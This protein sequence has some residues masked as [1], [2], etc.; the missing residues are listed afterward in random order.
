MGQYPST[1]PYEGDQ[2]GIFG[3]DFGQKDSKS[4]LL[5][6]AGAA[7][8]GIAAALVANPVLLNFGA[9]HGKRRRRSVSGDDSVHKLVYRGYQSKQTKV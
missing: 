4:Y 8:L 7:L 6:I 1:Y 2:N 5:P 9:M 3:Q